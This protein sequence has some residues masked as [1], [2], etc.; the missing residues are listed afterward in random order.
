[1]SDRRGEH[2]ALYVEDSVV[3]G[4]YNKFGSAR[5]NSM[6]INGETVDVTDKDAAAWRKLL[7][8]GGTRSITMNAAGAFDGDLQ[9]DEDVR[10]AAMSQALINVQMRSG[11]GAAT[12]I[13]QMAAQISSYERSGEYNQADMFSLTLESSGTVS[14]TPGT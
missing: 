1:M 8:G 12:D 3:A 5:T 14:Y 7:P 6:T 2:F 10:A 11:E 4:T 9:V 13:W